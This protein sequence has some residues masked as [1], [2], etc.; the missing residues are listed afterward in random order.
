M[1]TFQVAVAMLVW[2]ILYGKGS[3]VFGVLTAL[4]FVFL[5]VKLWQAKKQ[6]NGMVGVQ[7]SGI[8]TTDG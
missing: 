3:V 1:Y 6:F 8:E 2:S 4:P 5:G 7:V